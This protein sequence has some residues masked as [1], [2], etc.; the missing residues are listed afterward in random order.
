MRHDAFLYCGEADLLEIRLSVLDKVMDHFAIVE[1][2]T[3]FSGDR[4]PLFFEEQRARFAPWRDR[5][6]YTIVRDTPD[7]GTYRWGREHFQ[8]NALA[9]PLAIRGCK[10]GDIVHLS[11]IDEIPDPDVVAR[12]W[13]GS[14]R[15]QHSFYCLNVI[16]PSTYWVGTSSL[17]YFQLQQVTPQKIR[18]ERYTAAR[19]V[20]PGGWHF[21]TQ[22]TTEE[23]QRK[24][25]WFSHAEF[26]TPEYVGDTDRRRREM[27]DAAGK[28]TLSRVD[29]QA[30][31]FPEH[32]KKNAARYAHMIREDAK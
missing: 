1:S 20:D 10:S 25:H 19:V 12:N 31:Y 11:D 17:Y 14:F 29:L 24:L 21:S 26:D 13:R 16:Q 2:D 27:L 23:I 28:D 4:K 3:A 22:M 30:G 15:Q 6:S 7:T 8:R 32:L 9:R 5:I 18:D